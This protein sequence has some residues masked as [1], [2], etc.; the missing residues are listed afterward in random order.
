[1]RYVPQQD[2][3][4]AHYR[5][6][7]EWV[8]IVRT[9]SRCALR[10]ARKQI[11]S[12]INDRQFA[13]RWGDDLK[14][15]PPRGLWP[16]AQINWRGG[17]IFD[18]Y[19]L[20]DAGRAAGAARW[21]VLLLAPRIGTVFEKMLATFQQEPAHVVRLVQSSDM[22]NVSQQ[23]PSVSCRQKRGGYVGDLEKFMARYTDAVLVRMSNDAV[24][25]LYVEDCE[26]RTKAGEAPPKLPA[27]RRNI[28][29][30]VAKIRAN[31]L[32]KTVNPS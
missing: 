8:K 13:L 22:S 1:M 12:G 4:R 2:R 17:K 23:S 16:S 20:T 28:E 14:E 29:T 31:R 19:G 15:Q 30:Q 9:V 3:V 32:S 11:H 24:S 5:T 25:R 18:D 26:K 27:D 21:R 6:L 10:D 7:P